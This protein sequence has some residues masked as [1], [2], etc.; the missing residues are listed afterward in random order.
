MKKTIL[1]LLSLFLVFSLAAC[2]STEPASENEQPAVEETTGNNEPTYGGVI[3]F[4]YTQPFKGVLD[5]GFYGGQDDELILNFMAEAL[6]KTGDD[7]KPYPNIATWTESPDHKT[8]TFTIKEGVKW[9]NGD[10]L[11]V[12]DWKYSL[13]VIAHPDYTGARYSNVEMIVGAEE[14]H[15]GEADSIS[16]IKVIDPYT[17]E[18]T[19]KEAAVNTLDNL[20]SYP[21]PSKYYEGIAVKDLPNSPQ[22]RQNPIGTGPFKVKKIQP[23]EFV[24]LERFDDYWQGKPYLD[25][26]VYKIVDA[27][28]T[29]G[30]LQNG[31]VDIM[32][33]PASQYKQIKELPNTN[34]FEEPSLSYSYI[35]F[36]FGRWDATEEK[37]VMDN[38][39]FQDKRLRQAMAYALD[40][41]A[42]IDAFSNGLGEVINA[43]MPVVSW[44][45]A[46]DSE[47]NAY[48]YNPD[49][50][51]QLLDEA[52]YK[53]IDNDGFR[54]DPN[55]EK[56][57]VSFHA[58]SGSD[59]SEPRAQAIMQ[60]WHEV[61]LNAQLNGGSLKEFNLFYDMV[62]KDDP[63][64]DVFMGA[65]GLASDPDPTGLWRSNDVWNFPRWYTEESDRLIKEGI[66]EKA[67]DESYR[68]QVY[69]DWQKLVNEELPMIFMYAPV[70]VYAANKRLQ[71][72]HTNSFTSQVDTHLWWVTE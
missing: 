39:K 63:S 58:M 26:V 49:K 13:E 33:I 16:G 36:D 23:G 32:E 31:E 3:T 10:E 42:L 47:L 66:G 53:D 46:P 50:A 9:H 25:G 51:M 17:I 52:G 41:Q 35:G 11:T 64:I 24:E 8:F 72:V 67:F 28:L 5:Y 40:R 21:M 68:K 70:D 12:E 18:I 55:G 61:G 1:L 14:Y 43:P 15:T 4:A 56:F 45:K 34:L 2:S 54:E 44:A 57:T 69:V 27:N 62:E 19:V 6:L 30:L 37:V 20:W 59:I 38:P 29:E 22:V 48:E 7:L 71:N 60:M 65:W